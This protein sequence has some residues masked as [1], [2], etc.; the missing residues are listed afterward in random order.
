MS[1]MGQI[2]AI[3]TDNAKSNKSKRAE[4][5]E[6]F[7]IGLRLRKGATRD[8]VKFFM[9]AA[10]ELDEDVERDTSPVNVTLPNV[11]KEKENE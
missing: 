2:H 7:E 4:L 6:Y 11:S 8:S 10:Q 3:V 1:K 9:E 5:T